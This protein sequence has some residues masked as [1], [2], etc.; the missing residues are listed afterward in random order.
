MM[1]RSKKTGKAKVLKIEDL[2]KTPELS[3]VGS[4]ESDEQEPSDENAESTESEESTT[5]QPDEAALAQQKQYW[6]DRIRQM[7]TQIEDLNRKAVES[8]IT[9][10]STGGR[11]STERSGSTNLPNSNCKNADDFKAQAEAIEEQ[12]RV[13]RS[14]AI[15]KNLP[16]EWFQ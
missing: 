2:D 11:S 13:L 9:C 5:E 10:E 4:E 7:R 1:R 14:E 16:L 15:I 12:I 3:V 6:R 8:E